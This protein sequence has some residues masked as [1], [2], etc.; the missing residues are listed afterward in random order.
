MWIPAERLAHQ[1]YT[2]IDNA[3][4]GAP[5]PLS[6]EPTS[7]IAAVQRGPLMATPE[8]GSTAAIPMRNYDPFLA[9]SCSILSS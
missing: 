5:H 8:R 6:A 9:S 4:H 3:S 1:A 2:E 7:N